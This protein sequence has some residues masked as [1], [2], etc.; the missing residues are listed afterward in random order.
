MRVCVCMLEEHDPDEP[1]HHVKI[2]NTLILA[3]NPLRE[4]F[5]S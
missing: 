2:F 4:C 1:Y 5:V 3:F